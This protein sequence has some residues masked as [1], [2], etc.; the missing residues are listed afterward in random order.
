MTPIFRSEQGELCGAAQDGYVECLGIRTRRHQWVVCDPGH[1]SRPTKAMVH[2]AV[3]RPRI[4]AGAASWMVALP[5][6]RNPM[7]V[8]PTTAARGDRGV[9]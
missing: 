6:V 1:R 3:T 4:C 5:V 2:S 9:Q 8:A 7:L